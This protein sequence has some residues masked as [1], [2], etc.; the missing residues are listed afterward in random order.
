MLQNICS[1]IIPSTSP[2]EWPERTGFTASC[3][4]AHHCPYMRWSRQVSHGSLTAFRE[5]EVKLFFSNLK[6]LVDKNGY[7]PSRIYNV[8]ETA[9]TTVM[10]AKKVISG[11]GMRQVGVVKST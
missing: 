1:L 8:D 6:T 7:T 9:I 5:S 11:K 4:D 3:R 2:R 10:P